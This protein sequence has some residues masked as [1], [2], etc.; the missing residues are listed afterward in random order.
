[1]S[2][3]I[4]LISSLDEELKKAPSSSQNGS[5]MFAILTS[6]SHVCRCLR[7]VRKF[8]RF[9]I[10]PPLREV[11]TRPEESNTLKGRLVKLLTNSDISLKVCSFSAMVSLLFEAPILKKTAYPLLA[12]VNLATGRQCL[13]P[14]SAV[15]LCA[16]EVALLA[17]STGIAEAPSAGTWDQQSLIFRRSEIVAWPQ[18]ALHDNYSGML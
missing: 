8:L 11:I 2:A 14:A 17:L 3:I 10:L 5:K 15:L 16:G 9:Q 12:H 7:L 18:R 13:R 4:A 1:M 6:L